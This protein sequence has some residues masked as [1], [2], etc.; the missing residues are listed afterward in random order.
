[1]KRVKWEFETPIGISFLEASEGQHP[2]LRHL[3]KKALLTYLFREIYN[4]IL[5]ME[6]D[7]RIGD[8][9]GVA[10][11]ILDFGNIMHLS[12][13][14]LSPVALGAPFGVRR[15]FYENYDAIGDLLHASLNHRDYYYNQ[16][17]DHVGE[18]AYVPCGNKADLARA[19]WRWY[20]QVFEPVATRFTRNGAEHNA[21]FVK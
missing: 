4:E 1:M 11:R 2:M 8:H 13:L 16:W 10:M 3:S 20:Y 12:D 17:K 9:S 15:E 18:S 6:A 7:P 21:N 19:L 14:Y 5:A